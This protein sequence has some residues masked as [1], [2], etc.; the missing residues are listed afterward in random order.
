MSDV[1]A[2]LAQG[3]FVERELMT[4]SE[5]NFENLSYREAK[6]VL[7]FVRAIRKRTDKLLGVLE[8]EVQNAMDVQNEVAR[9]SSKRMEDIVEQMQRLINRIESTEKK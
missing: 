3:K 5:Y 7:A 1:K 9:D 6:T 8:N 2:I 4:L